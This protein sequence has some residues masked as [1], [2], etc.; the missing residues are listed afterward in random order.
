VARAFRP[1]PERTS[2][3]SA[4]RSLCGNPTG[5]RCGSRTAP[6]SRQ[7]VLIHPPVSQQSLRLVLVKS[8]VLCSFSAQ[9]ALKTR[10]KRA[11]YA[12]FRIATSFVFKYFLASFPLFFIFCS[13]LHSAIPRLLRFSSRSEA[14]PRQCVRKMT[15]IIGYHRPLSLSSGKCKVGQT[16]G[17]MG[18]W[19]TEQVG[20][21]VQPS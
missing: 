19:R 15:T 11:I 14:C 7:S 6:T 20:R 3:M 8:D 16:V 2:N 12:A 10:L 1:P 13:S 9:I 4:L 17:Q 5:C 18:G 21:W